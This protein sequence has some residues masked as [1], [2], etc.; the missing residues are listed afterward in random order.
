MRCLADFVLD[1]DLCLKENSGPFTLDSQDGSYSVIFSNAEHDPALLDS[2]LSAQL[3]FEAASIEEA[4]EPAQRKISEALNFLTYATNRKFVLRALK[5]IVDWTPGLVQ[6]Q[7]LIY[8]ETPEW[9]VAE[10][11]L[12]NIFLDTAQ[13]LMAMGAGEIQQTAMRWYRLA[14]QSENIE[15]QFSYFWFALEIAA[16]ALKGT[17]KVPSKCPKCQSPLLCEKCGEHPTHR[18]YSGEAIQ[19]VIQLVHP[20]GSDEV[21]KTLQLI[22]HTLMHGGRIAS[23]LDQLPCDEQEAT[24]KLSYVTWNAISRMFNK[25]D[26]SPEQSMTFGYVDNVVRRKIVGSAH[27]VVGMP[28]DPNNPRIS[29]FPKINFEVTKK[30]V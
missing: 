12:D 8:V 26:P 10:P 20:T 4:R 17:E 11:A 13:R 16:E 2:V 9:D 14:I 19:Q 1:S 29:D 21:F 7:V 3:I 18:R 22:R 27:V 28:G 15:E 5:R 24:N 23:I 25:A 6:R 30:Q